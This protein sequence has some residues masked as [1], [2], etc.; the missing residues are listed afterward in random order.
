[1]KQKQNYL[2]EIA[3]TCSSCG[4]LINHTHTVEKCQRTQKRKQREL[5]NTYRLRGS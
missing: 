4:V 2:N 1:M 5:R 3:K